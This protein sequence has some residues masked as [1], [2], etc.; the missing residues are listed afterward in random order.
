MVA[1]LVAQL[2]ELRLVGTL[3]AVALIALV[4]FFFWRKRPPN[5]NYSDQGR[6]VSASMMA[7]ASQ[8]PKND[9]L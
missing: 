4:V 9:D 7:D 3:A 6:R 8:Q 1:C 5:R 2:L